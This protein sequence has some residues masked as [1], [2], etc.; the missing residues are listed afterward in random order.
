MRV[1]LVGGAVRDRLLGRASSD[2]D[3]VVVGARPEQLLAQGFQAVGKDFPVFLHPKTKQEYALARTERKAGSGYTGF[4]C[5]SHPNISLE[6]DL[7]R[8]DLTIN[9]IAQDAQGNFY[10]PYGGRA[11]LKG[12]ILR[13]ISP[14]FAEDPLRVLRVARFAA[15]FRYLGFQVASETLALMRQISQSGELASLTPE[16]VWLETD[17][18]LREQNPEVYFQLLYQVGAL[19]ALFPEL[20]ALAKLEKATELGE[21]PFAKPQDPPPQFQQSLFAHS[22]TA[23]QQAALLSQDRNGKQQTALRFAAL[24]TR[25]DQGATLNHC[26]QSSQTNSAP[27][28]QLCTRLKTPNEVKQLALLGC[29][30]HQQIHQACQLSPEALLKLFQ[31]LDAWRKPQQLALLLLVCEADY[32]GHMDQQQP[33]KTEPVYPQAQYLWQ[34]YQQTLKVD[35]QQIIAQGYQKQGIK[36]E[37]HRRRIEGLRGYR[38]LILGV[39]V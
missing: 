13:H 16:R 11:D 34:A 32:R 14:A 21:E 24:L 17:K 20:A 2:Q 1:Y 3:W 7:A 10:D 36:R 35:V 30:Y 27:L 25:L 28:E 15:R 12:K 39:H 5:D 19:T 33:A 9:A 4:I 22:L 8:R 6:Q 23:L 29:Q 38:R 18:A 31:R 26:A 37:I